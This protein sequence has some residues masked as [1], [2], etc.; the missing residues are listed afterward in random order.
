M[1]RSIPLPFIRLI[2]STVLAACALLALTLS[3]HLSSSSALQ[4]QNSQWAVD[5]SASSIGFTADSLFG[6]VPGTFHEWSFNGTINSDVTS[7]AG[8]LTVQVASIDTNNSTRDDHLRNE[9]FFEV[10]RFPTATFRI[11][12]VEPDGEY[13]IVSGSLTIRDVTRPVEME[14]K[15][16]VTGNQAV[17]NGR[18][19]LN[20]TDYGIDYNSRLNP[21]E[22]EVVLEMKI[23]LKK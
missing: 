13:L 18:M 17:L 11:Q 2:R 19:L 3:A 4:A 8:T 16:S 21:I 15:K 1:H 14:F 9:D 10:T 22:E 12:S 5:K 7:A 23:V 20:R 6:D